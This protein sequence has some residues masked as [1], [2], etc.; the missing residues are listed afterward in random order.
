VA[1]KTCPRFTIA[2]SIGN[3]ELCKNSIS[4]R[5]NRLDPQ[6]SAE[7]QRD[8]RIAVRDN[9]TSPPTK[10]PHTIPFV[11][12]VPFVVPPAARPLCHFTE[13]QKPKKDTKSIQ[14]NSQKLRYPRVTV[15]ENTTQ[16]IP[17][18]EIPRSPNPFVSSV[19]FVVAPA[20]TQLSRFNKPQKA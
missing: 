5:S 4:C 20:A 17:H 13:P 6:T 12:S 7:S 1:F 10:F 3:N 19:P 2:H 8:P 16:P 14:T 15:R 11:S 18:S 9:T